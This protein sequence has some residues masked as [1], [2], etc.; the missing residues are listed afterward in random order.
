M[1]KDKELETV[2]GTL[3]KIAWHFTPRFIKIAALVIFVEMTFIIMTVNPQDRIGLV[4]AFM[5][6]LPFILVVFFMSIIEGND[7]K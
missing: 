7:K 6:M 2:L 1:I 5:C 3:L 4:V